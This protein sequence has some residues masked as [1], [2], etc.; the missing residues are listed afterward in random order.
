VT[1]AV[2]R[3]FLAGEPA[4][5]ASA[6]IPDAE[7]PAAL[8]ACHDLEGLLVELERWAVATDADV[9]GFADDVRGYYQAFLAQVSGQLRV[10]RA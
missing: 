2:D 10:A 8:A 7:V 3:A 9:L 1:Q 4:F 5:T 6:T